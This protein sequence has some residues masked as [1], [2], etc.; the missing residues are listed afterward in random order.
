MQIITDA[1]GRII[2]MCPTDD[3]SPARRRHSVQPDNPAQ[4]PNAVPVLRPR[5]GQVLHVIPL[6]AEFAGMPLKEIHAT[7]RV[8]VRDGKS[9]LER[10]K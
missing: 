2:A 8:V 4:R 10:V 6:S 9:R 1:T 5:A 3:E 7:H